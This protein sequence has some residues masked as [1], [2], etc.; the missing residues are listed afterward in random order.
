MRF[1]YP[2]KL[3]GDTL[4]DVLVEPVTPHFVISETLDVQPH[5]N[6]RD[7]TV[8]HTLTG[9]IAGYAPSRATAIEAAKAL[10]ALDDDS[11]AHDVWGFL[12]VDKMPENLAAKVS[13]L[14]AELQKSWESG[15]PETSRADSD[16]I[17]V[18][19]DRPE[20]YEDVHPELLLDDAINKGFV[21]HIIEEAALKET[22]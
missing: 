6:N 21:W 9:H 7:W 13:T 22:S 18:K 16:G 20:G 4:Q 11:A 5:Q 14:S 10:E 15:A 19:I 8:T 1:W 3:V 17:L 2:L 12:D